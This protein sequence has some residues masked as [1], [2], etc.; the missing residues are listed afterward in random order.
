MNVQNDADQFARDLIIGGMATE[1]AAKTANIPYRAGRSIYARLVA[2]GVITNT[3]TGR[4]PE[5][6][7]AQRQQVFDQLQAGKSRTK[8]AAEI[9][10]SVSTI[11][12][13]AQQFIDAGGKIPPT[14]IASASSQFRRAGVK[15]GSIDAAFAGLPSSAI[16][17][18]VKEIP[19]GCTV[20]D[21]LRSIVF[22][23]VDEM[24][25]LPDSVRPPRVMFTTR[26]AGE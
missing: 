17:R 9:G 5:I 14:A 1:A 24:G 26:R 18:I 11:S 21:W 8:I 20:A 10:V 25:A 22:D 3:R 15:V 13:F 16:N 6:T 19:K 4:K 7:D 2:E 23:V 12:R